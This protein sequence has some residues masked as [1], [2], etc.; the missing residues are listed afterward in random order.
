MDDIAQGA[1][2]A[3]VRDEL[4]ISY[5]EHLRKNGF[6]EQVKKRLQNEPSGEVAPLEA[7]LF[8]LLW[9]S[10]P[11]E[12]TM[13]ALPCLKM[14]AD[15][16]L[17]L[18]RYL[19]WLNSHF[20]PLGLWVEYAM[21]GRIILRTAIRE[22]VKM[23]DPLNLELVRRAEILQTMVARADNYGRYVPGDT[24][25][26]ASDASAI[27]WGVVATNLEGQRLCAKAALHDAAHE[28]WSIP[29]LELYAILEA[30][31]MA[32]WL[33][34]AD[35]K[36]RRVVVLSDSSI[37]V[38]RVVNT[39]AISTKICAWD[40]RAIQHLREW[41]S[42]P[43]S[44]VII[45]H[46]AGR[47][48]PSDSASRG[49][50]PPSSISEEYRCYVR[51][52]DER[53]D[54]LKERLVTG[55]L[56]P[57][58]GLYAIQ[59]GSDHGQ[60]D[61]GSSRV[62]EVGSDHGQTDDGSS[63]VPEVGS[64]PGHTDDGSSRVP[65]VGSDHGQTDD[66]SSRVPEVGSD[67]GHTDDGSSRVPEVG[68]DP[69]HTDDGSSR[70]PE[71][72]SDPGHTDDG[73]SRVPEVGSDPGHTDDGSSRVPEVGSDPGH[74]DDG[75]NR[76]VD[77]GL[78]TTTADKR[79]HAA[80]R[81][82]IG[83]VQKVVDSQAKD[84]FCQMVLSVLRHEPTSLS[85]TESSRLRRSYVENDDVIYRINPVDNEQIL[86][87]EEMRRVA[88]SMVHDL[89]AHCGTGKLYA[90]LTKDYGLWWPK[91]TKN[92]R[93]WT[94]ACTTCVMT[95]SRRQ[96]PAR[97]YG[98]SL[99]S[100]QLWEV[101]AIDIGGPYL[102]STIAPDRAAEDPSEETP[103]MYSLIATEAVTRYMVTTPLRRKTSECIADALESLCWQFGFPV[104]LCHDRDVSLMGGAVK[105]F[106]EKYGIRQVPNPPYA[107]I[108]AFWEPSHH[109]LHLALK[110]L[111]RAA[112]AP[113]DS[114]P[115]FLQHATWV[116][117]N[118]V[119]PL[120]GISGER[121]T[122]CELVRLCGSCPPPCY[123]ASCV[124]SKE[125]QAY[126]ERRGIDGT[127]KPAQARR[128]LAHRNKMEGTLQNYLRQWDDHRAQL[129]DKM[130]SSRRRR[131]TPEGHVKVGDVVRV[132]K[133]HHKLQSMWSEALYMVDDI[134]GEIA[135]LRNHSGELS[136][137]FLFNLAVATDVDPTELTFCARPT[138]FRAHNSTV[139]V[140]V[141]QPSKVDQSKARLERRER[142][143]ALSAGA[144][145]C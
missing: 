144:G 92:I 63:R 89:F 128:R 74:T 19:S 86:V 107:P 64:D 137:Q 21:A 98:T 117:N 38:Q 14:A 9:L 105:K 65:E 58:N 24:V 33:L 17:T 90:I 30:K 121:V 13:K 104:V 41:V 110:H 48:N 37:N 7:S 39:G 106:V 25:I 62:P 88:F 116:V 102:G 134:R 31:K 138:G 16:T 26:V 141:Y 42:D 109:L 22:G 142:R 85:S 68:S 71:V 56:P 54:E 112:R 78:Q 99:K 130:N 44:P 20:D 76:A 84:R 18:R 8:G 118:S 93:Q 3:V 111:M 126:S 52:L 131:G 2:T 55:K 124:L 82:D 143:A 45:G 75:L 28:R 95:H 4:A 115:R 49:M 72:G 94:R 46:I 81:K 36:T 123:R 69:G 35:P 59:V 77:A 114:W 5:S 119:L 23:D 140:P 139:S 100:G 120:S 11:D 51:G 47:L 27:G 103:Y 136:V 32:L 70:V 129:V 113:T 50:V 1:D 40:I 108:R 132:F 57:M 127:S 6:T 67:P 60:T 91:M 87:P 61:D 79:S 43:D 96:E 53:F 133:P 12:L 34:T 125:A 10:G 15:N 97:A 80:D 29:R 101:L 73:S 83:L 145:E 135:S 122:A 66:G